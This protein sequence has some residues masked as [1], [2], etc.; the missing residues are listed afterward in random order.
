MHLLVLQ[1]LPD[2]LHLHEPETCWKTCLSE[3]CLHRVLSAQ[4]RWDAAFIQ[5]CAVKT[6]N[7][8]DKHESSCVPLCGCVKHRFFFLCSV[9]NKNNNQF[10]LPEWITHYRKVVKNKQTKNL[11]TTPVFN[12]R[13]FSSNL[14]KLV[15][16]DTL[17]TS[18]GKQDLDGTASPKWFHT[19]S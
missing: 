18:A 17:N 8:E 13:R 14:S 15:H 6:Q 9:N 1:F 16:Q 7:E 10:K 2:I 12:H 11:Q 19:S 4:T 3:F 5:L